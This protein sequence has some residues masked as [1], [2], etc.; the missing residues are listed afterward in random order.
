[1]V[2]GFRVSPNPLIEGIE[3]LQIIIGSQIW[4]KVYS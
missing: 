3:L 2:L 1:M 4:F